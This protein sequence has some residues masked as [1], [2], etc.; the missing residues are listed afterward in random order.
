MS[1]S[2]KR[3]ELWLV[4]KRGD[5]FLTRMVIDSDQ[6]IDGIVNLAHVYATSYECIGKPY[7]LD[8]DVQLVRK[9]CDDWFKAMSDAYNK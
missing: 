7:E 9:I 1:T 4:R 6:Q 8:V 2:H 3:G 5:Q